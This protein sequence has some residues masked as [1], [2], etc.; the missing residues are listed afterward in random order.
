MSD[1]NITLT[2]DGL[3]VT[4]PEGVTILEAA[5]K[6]NVK[7]PTLCDHPDL[8]KRAVCRLCVVE[9]D[10]RE[11]LLASCAHH[12][13][14]GMNIVTNNS[15]I[16]DIRKT[17]I[18]L[19]LASHPHDDCLA[20]IS[21]TKCELQSLAK[22]Y[23]TSAS[24]FQKSFSGQNRK[25]TKDI[26]CN[27]LVRD[28]EK[29]VKCGRCVEACQNIQTVQAIN[30]SGRSANYEI[31]TPYAQA[32]S[33][34]SCV[35][36][37]HCAEVCPVGAIYEYDQSAEAWAFLT[38]KKHEMAIKIAPQEAQAVCAEL[39]LPTEAITV[40]KIITGLKRMGFSGVYNAESF[41][42]MSAN[43]EAAELL[44]RIKSSRQLPM[45]SCCSTSGVKFVKEFYTDLSNHLSEAKSPEQNFRDF[46]NKKALVSI[47]PCIAKKYKKPSEGD[48]QNTGI[49]MSV[50]ELARLIHLSG[51]ELS[52]VQ[53][54][55]FDQVS[56]EAPD[57]ETKGKKPDRL[58]EVCGLANAR[59]VL[60]A[61][62]ASNCDADYVKILSCPSGCKTGVMKK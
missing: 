57:I 1:K 40:G 13:E 45:I 28:M 61:I 21:N 58:L 49:I 52:A 43:E 17:I 38:E 19:I 8:C 35:L 50:R 22:I 55:A 60:D 27:V 62:R 33:D 34:S 11:K 54:S 9:N 16:F 23:S 24:P 31:S 26:S 32:L 59:K 42:A 25:K 53:E 12:A 46:F 18:S 44:D 37:G 2:I 56:G 15:R 47:A 7:I 14:E 10:G 30:T 6:V 29:C 5:R 3:S 36:C 39:G 4:V 20:C 51:I 48:I 41:E